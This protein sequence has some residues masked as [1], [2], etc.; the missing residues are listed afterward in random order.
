MTDV[1]STK[2]AVRRRPRER[3]A[4]RRRPSARRR[5]GGGRR[6]RARGPVRGRDLV[7]DADRDDAAGCCYERL[8]RLL[9]GARRAAR[10]DRRRRPRPPDGHRQPPAA[11]AR[12]RARRPGRRARSAASALPATGPSFRDATRVAGANPA[13]W[14]DIFARQPRRAGRR[15]RRRHR[16]GSRA[17]ATQ[18]RAG[19]DAGP[20][21]RE[22]R[23][24]RRRLLEADLRRR[25][26]ERAA[27][28]GAE[29]ARD[30]RPASRSRSARR[31]STSSTWRSIPPPTCSRARSPSGSPAR[32]R[33][34][35]RRARRGLGFAVARRDSR[36]RRARASACAASCAP[37]PDKSISHRAAILGAM[38]RRPVRIR[39][40]LRAADTASTLEAVRAPGRARARSAPTRCWCAA[41]G[42]AAPRPRT[43][44][45]TSATP[46]RCIRLL[47]GW[48]AGAG[49]GAPGRSTAT[50]RSA[51]ARSTA[52]PSRC[53]RMGAKVDCRDGRLPP[54]TVE[55]AHAARRS[56]TS[57]RWRAR[58]SSRACCSPACS[59]TARRRSSSR[60]AAATTPSGMLAAAGV[61]RA[62]ATGVASPCRHAD[63]LELGRGRRA[64]RLLLGGVLHRRGVLV[65]GSRLRA[66]RRRREPD[67][68]RLPAR[69]SSGWAR[70]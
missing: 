6:A 65:P 61:D 29:P 51:G 69:R 33:R 54:F 63:E 38:S 47:P 15:A 56:S 66:A 57:C 28:R 35:C 22:A 9:S 27:R 52:S 18:L 8:Y 20:L 19:A 7:P 30:R 4:L 46:A 12:Q 14:R 3:P 10:G 13:L 39:N 17:C 58:R 36:A 31:A 70:S 55:G 40:Y 32:A 24:G 25:P 67:P 44:R 50:T 43:G 5:R 62:A 26:G 49:R 41:P 42:C 21:E 34:A 23:S 60:A 16:D 11:R 68:H 45:S 59:P 37:P 64:R 53:A 1:G 48:L 2:R